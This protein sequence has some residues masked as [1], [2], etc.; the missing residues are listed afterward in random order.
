MVRNG[1]IDAETGNPLIRFCWCTDGPWDIRDFVVKQCFISKVGAHL[2]AD[3][4]TTVKVSFHSIDCHPTLAL[5]RRYGRA[6][7]GRSVDGKVL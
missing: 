7:T 1:L 2:V 5:W 3:G 6:P 4:P